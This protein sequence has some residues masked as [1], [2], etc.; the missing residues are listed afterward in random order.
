MRVLR[1]R[2]LAPACG[3]SRMRTSVAS[4]LPSVCL[5]QRVNGGKVFSQAAAGHGLSSN[6]S[7]KRTAKKPRPLN[8][9]VRLNKGEIYEI[10]NI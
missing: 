5:W 8:S 1:P 3:G 9:S 6:T 7:S 2:E 10:R 4:G